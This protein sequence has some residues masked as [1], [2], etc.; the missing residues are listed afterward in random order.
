[1]YHMERTGIRK[2]L[3]FCKEKKIHW[4]K[5][6]MYLYEN[7]SMTISLIYV[8]NDALIIDIYSTVTGTIT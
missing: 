3:S 8:L 7:I 4:N 6:I 2:K 5:F 1:M